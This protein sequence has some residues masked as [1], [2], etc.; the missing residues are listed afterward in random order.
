[1]RE[2]NKNRQDLTTSTASGFS[3]DELRRR[4]WSWQ[5]TASSGWRRF[6]RRSLVST[7]APTQ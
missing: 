7:C 6:T 4:L 5:G 3:D 2:E 1:M